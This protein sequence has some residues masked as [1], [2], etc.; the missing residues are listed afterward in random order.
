MVRIWFFGAL[1][2]AVQAGSFAVSISATAT[3]A[4]LKYTSPTDNACQVMVT[5]T[6]TTL[7]VNDLNTTL[8][9]GADLDSRT[10]GALSRGRDRIFIAG[11]RTAE[12]AVNGQ[13]YSR[14]LEAFTSH[15]FAVNCDGDVT[16]GSFTTANP[17]LGNTAPELPAWNADTFGGWS[18]PQINWVDRS[19]GYIDPLTGILLKRLTGPGDFANK[20]TQ[21]FAFA[22][23]RNNAWSN[24]QNAVSGN[25]SSHVPTGDLPM[26]PVQA[27]ALLCRVLMRPFRDVAAPPAAPARPFSVKCRCPTGTS[28]VSPS[29]R[30]KYSST[31]SMTS[32]STFARKSDRR[33]SNRTTIGWAGARTS[34]GWFRS[35]H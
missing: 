2:V 11:K 29:R 31:C 23:D 35:Y 8:F 6:E 32:S 28:K 19:Q 26:K 18:W 33:V 21:Q 34:S 12:K 30:M 27:P 13:Y 17:P 20:Q 14:A 16:S 25:A 22:L 5:E 9:P 24:P 7:R 10:E 4:V 1:A 3:Q 15:D